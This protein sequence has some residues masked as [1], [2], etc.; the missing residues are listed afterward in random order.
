MGGSSHTAQHYDVMTDERREPN[1]T[2]KSGAP[3]PRWRPRAQ[4]I[5][6]RP[7]GLTLRAL[8]APHSLGLGGS[9]GMTDQTGCATSLPFYLCAPAFPSSFR[10]RRHSQLWETQLC[11][12]ARTGKTQYG[13]TWHGTPGRCHASQGPAARAT[14]AT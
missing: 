2:F 7:L 12:H 10:R 9:D 3:P 5:P 1:L 4:N 11:R 14:L 8:S 6:R 13:N